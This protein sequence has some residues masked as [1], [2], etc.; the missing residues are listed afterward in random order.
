MLWFK[1]NEDSEQD[2]KINELM[3]KVETLVPNASQSDQQAIRSRIAAAVSGGY[4]FADTLHNIYL[5]YGYPCSLD[6]FNFWNMYRRLGI[7]ESVVELPSDASWMRPPKIESED[8][9]FVRDIERLVNNKKLWVRLKGLDTRQRVGRYA[10]LFMRVRDNKSPDQPLETKRLSGLGA[11]VEMVPL[12]EGQLSVLTTEDNPKEDNYAQ[13][14]MYQFNGSGTGNRNEKQA[15]SFSIHPSRLVMAAEGADNGSI[16]GKSSL[17]A[18][19]NSLMDV[20]K[21]IG[22]GAEGFYKNAAQNILF[23]LMDASSAKSNETLLNKF[24]ENYDDFAN[25]RMRRAMWTPGLDPTTLQSELASPKEFFNVALSDVA[26]SAKIPATII[27]GQQT[28]RLASNED[29]RS[30]LS[31][32]NSRNENFVTDMITNVLDWMINVGLLP[33][34]KYEVEWDD[35]LALSQKELLELGLSMA[36]TNSK[37]FLS[38]GDRPFSSEEIREVSGFDAVP[39]VDPGGEGDDDFDEDSDNE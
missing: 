9:R 37:N 11:L 29:S 19:Y 14:T 10:G 18:P 16:Y 22:G 8:P 33:V 30:F 35:L 24:N 36:D 27:I 25:N 38:G 5:D 32:V 13:P 12:Y 23:K 1:K 2:I 4:D 39:E 21:I 15:A 28:G 17:E 31:M 3:K 20:R 34:A 6:F 26:A 7:A